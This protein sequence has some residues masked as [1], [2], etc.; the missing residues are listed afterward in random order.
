MHKEDAFV[1]KKH[2]YAAPNI[3]SN[4]PVIWV[5]EKY[6]LAVQNFRVHVMQT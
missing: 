3:L 1:D 5:F 6:F 2:T 4:D